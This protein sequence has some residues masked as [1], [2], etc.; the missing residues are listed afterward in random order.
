MPGIKCIP[1]VNLLL[2]SQQHYYYHWTNGEIAAEGLNNLPI[3][4]SW[5]EKELRSGW[6]QNLGC[7]AT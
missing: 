4:H 6:L 2:S 5:S 1:Y 3:L 7:V